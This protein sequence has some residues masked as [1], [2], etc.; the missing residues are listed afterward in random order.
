[1]DIVI[2]IITNLLKILKYVR[3]HSL[4]S[5]TILTFQFQ[6]KLCCYSNS[7][8]YLKQLSFWVSHSMAY[9]FLINVRILAS[10]N[11]ISRVCRNITFSD[12]SST[13]ISR[14]SSE[15]ISFSTSYV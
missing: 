15:S 14:L 9:Q 13:A 12:L 4:V 2:K 7:K 6:K 5:E 10:H 3:F 11:I 8:Q 1:M